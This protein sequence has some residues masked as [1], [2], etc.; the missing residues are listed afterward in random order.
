MSRWIIKLFLVNQVQTWLQVYSVGNRN[1]YW[2]AFPHVLVTVAQMSV[3]QK[4]QKHREEK[5]QVNQR[6]YK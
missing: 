4:K 2:F 1:K 6:I 5:E 3:E